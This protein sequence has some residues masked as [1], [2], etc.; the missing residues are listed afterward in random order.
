MKCKLIGVC[1]V[2]AKSTESIRDIPPLLMRLVLAYG[3]FGPAKMKWSNMH[4]IGEWFESMG[5]PLPYLN[6]Y[7]AGTVEALGVVLL[8]LGLGTRLI[9]IPL[10]FVMIIAIFT[11]H[12][13][14]GF[15]AG[16]NG[17]EIPLYYM[18]MLFTLFVNGAGRWSLDHYVQKLQD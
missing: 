10:I 13:A 12:F 14:N 18:I 15:E 2:L 1:K 3:F 11:V 16:S 8:I 17:F 9:S 5:Y 7:I 6:A 4:A